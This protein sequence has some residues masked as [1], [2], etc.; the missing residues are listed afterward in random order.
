MKVLGED[1]GHSG[2]FQSDPDRSQSPL[3]ED[4]GTIHYPRVSNQ[5]HINAMLRKRRRKK[6][7]LQKARRFDNGEYCLALLTCELLYVMYD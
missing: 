7:K 6:E 2:G 5:V 1:E 4:L 3:G